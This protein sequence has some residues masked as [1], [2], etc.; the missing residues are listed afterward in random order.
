MSI[1]I[2][3]VEETNVDPRYKLGHVTSSAST[4]PGKGH[5]AVTSVL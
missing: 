3:R 2:K 4:P 5:G 1:L